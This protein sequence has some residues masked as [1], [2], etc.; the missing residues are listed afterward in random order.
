[1]ECNSKHNLLC[2]V[3]RIQLI[4]ACL[5]S[6]ALKSL[7]TYTL[8]VCLYCGLIDAHFKLHRCYF[9]KKQS[10]KQLSLLM[11]DCNIPIK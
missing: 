1:M 6:V 8:Q 10:V 5:F 11:H 3:Q 2:L 9:S 4:E 7:Y